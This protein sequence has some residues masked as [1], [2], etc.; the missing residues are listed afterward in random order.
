MAFFIKS[1]GRYFV[2]NEDSTLIL[3]QQNFGVETIEEFKSSTPLSNIKKM[4]NNIKEGGLTEGI[5]NTVK[6]SYAMNKLK[7]NTEKHGTIK[8]YF[9]TQTD[10]AKDKYGSL[11]PAKIIKGQINDLKQDFN[12][13][14]SSSKK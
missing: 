6:D 1:K 14:K 12:T 9:K 2:F 5:K 13:L 8:G 11:N 10:L 4:N 3:G 7:D